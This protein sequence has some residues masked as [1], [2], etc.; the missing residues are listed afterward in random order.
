[1]RY[2]YIL[3]ALVASAFAAWLFVANPD[4]DAQQKQIP[5]PPGEELPIVDLGQGET[6]QTTNEPVDNRTAMANRFTQL[7]QRV[8]DA[9]RHGTG[10]DVAKAA[11]ELDARLAG[12]AARANSVLMSFETPLK[13][14]DYDA[15]RSQVGDG[16][17]TV[18]FS[19]DP[20]IP[21]VYTT[22]SKEDPTVA[23][24]AMFDAMSD[25]DRNSLPR[26]ST[27][28]VRIV[29]VQLSLESYLEL[30]ESKVLS[31]PAMQHFVE[32]RDSRDGAGAPVDVV[33]M[34]ALR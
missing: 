3:A 30:A 10:S 9:R 25:E 33:L 2:G 27:D 6:S 32:L 8:T 20:S 26:F 13:L 29:G 23:I 31:E 1:M 4:V 18:S 7:E 21:M 14:S 5:V 22:R 12:S 15:L 34:E 24:G 16:W 11:A 19:D 17:I 28:A